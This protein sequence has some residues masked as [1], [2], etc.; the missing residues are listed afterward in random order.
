ME[1]EGVMGEIL[2]N[3]E[4]YSIDCFDSHYN[5]WNRIS[6]CPTLKEAISQR[7]RFKAYDIE[8]REYRIVKRTIKEE[9]IG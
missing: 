2:K 3:L 1:Q 5:R 4:E 8:Q 6:N 9:V 7:D